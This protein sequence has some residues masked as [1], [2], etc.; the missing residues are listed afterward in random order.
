MNTFYF[1][2]QKLLILMFLNGSIYI[3]KFIAK[4]NQQYV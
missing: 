2:F 3:Y 1:I 4:Y